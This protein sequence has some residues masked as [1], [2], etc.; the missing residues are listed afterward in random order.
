MDD[1]TKLHQVP[2]QKVPPH[3]AALS[4]LVVNAI[5]LGIPTDCLSYGHRARISR[6]I[7]ER[8]LCSHIVWSSIPREHETAAFCHLYESLCL[9]PW[10]KYLVWSFM[11]MKSVV[12]GGRISVIFLSPFVTVSFI[13]MIGSGESSV[14]WSQISLKEEHSGLNWPEVLNIHT[15]PEKIKKE[16][17][18]SKQGL[19]CEI[20]VVIEIDWGV[21]DLVEF[22]PLF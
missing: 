1:A 12:V 5:I 8:F 18:A 6:P 9:V 22:K 19:D 11:M 10:R 7:Y 17:I 15:K 21:I 3:T 16:S 4:G 13:L 14:Q 20:E 2:Y